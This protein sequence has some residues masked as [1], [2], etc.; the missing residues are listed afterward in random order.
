MPSLTAAERDGHAATSL[1]FV[2]LQLLGRVP[3]EREED[4]VERRPAQADVVDLDPLVA[5]PADDVDELRRRRR[6]RRS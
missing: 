1:V 2:G 5:E 6:S 3:G 4:V